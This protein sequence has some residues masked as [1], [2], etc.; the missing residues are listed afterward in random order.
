MGNDHVPNEP[1]YILNSYN[2]PLVLCSVVSGR[3]TIPRARSFWQWFWTNEDS[4][5]I[6]CWLAGTY[7]TNHKFVSRLGSLRPISMLRIEKL[8]VV[9]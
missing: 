9:L 4:P 8:D 3:G 6:N 2:H 7:D 5:R 1:C